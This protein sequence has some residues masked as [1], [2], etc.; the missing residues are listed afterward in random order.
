MATAIVRCYEELNDFLPAD[1]RKRDIQINFRAPA[2]VRHVIESLGVPH[3][4]VELILVNG[5]SVDLE[6]RLA[7]GDRVTLYPVFE[8][9]D[10]SPLVRLRERPLRR[11][12]FLVDAHLGRLARY[13]RMLGFDTLYRNDLGDP[14]MVRL[15]EQ[16]RRILLT[17]DR[18]LLMHRGLTHGC[19]LRERKPRAQLAE[20]VRRLDLPAA[21]QPFTR[22]MVCNGPLG[23]VPKEG[24]LEK[25]PPRVRERF[26]EYRQCA[27]CGKVYWCGSHFDRMRSII[28][29]LC[30]GGREGD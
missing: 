1:R 20:V 11:P 7:D 25:I 14:L 17:R 21:L 24:V 23:R 29:R 12:R 9:L 4:E 26:D 5:V 30:E 15:A 10:V 18:A 19:Y 28:Q 16:E 27:A 3:T 6:A 8:A 13:L 2:P 22:C